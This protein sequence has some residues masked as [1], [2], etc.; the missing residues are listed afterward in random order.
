M[1]TRGTVR[2]LSLCKNVTPG[3]LKIVLQAAEPGS[4]RGTASGLECP[5]SSRA[6]WTRGGR[7]EGKGRGFPASS[8]S[9]SRDAQV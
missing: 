7:R 2:G 8:F 6:R 5:P 4:H 3:R 1:P 9:D